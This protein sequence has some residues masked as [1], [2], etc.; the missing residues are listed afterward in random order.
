MKNLHKHRERERE[1]MDDSN[2]L[3]KLNRR[4]YYASLDG[5]DRI[6]RLPE[7]ILGTIV[8]LLPLKQALAMSTLSRQW[9]YVWT[10]AKDLNFESME[11][12]S[13]APERKY[14]EYVD[15]VVNQHVDQKVDRFSFCFDVGYESQSSINNWIKFAMRNRVQ[16]LELESLRD[17]VFP[18]YVLDQ[19]L[20][21]HKEVEVGFTSLKELSLVNV[22]V[23][24]EAIDYLLSK[25]PLLERLQVIRSLALRDLRVVGRPSL[26]LKHLKIQL[27][28]L[29]QRV[30]IVDAENLVSFT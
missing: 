21:A 26:A 28:F 3:A 8:C 30:E 5:K 15:S 12:C 23:D 24:G 13:E 19:Q 10:C 25:C 1:N 27:C 6:S 4:L 16:V 9:R 17:S 29:L 11:R 18:Q 2:R 7:D 14:V 20:L 22:M